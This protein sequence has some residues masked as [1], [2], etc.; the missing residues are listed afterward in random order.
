QR[1]AQELARLETRRTE[2][3][4]EITLLELH[5]A[6]T[7]LAVAASV[8][9]LTDLLD[10]P[11]AFRAP[12]VTPVPSPAPGEPTAAT[13]PGS[14][15]AHAADEPTESDEGHRVDAITSAE[16]SPAEETPAGE[17][18]ADEALAD[19]APADDVPGETLADEMLAGET[20]LF[21]PSW[22][23][24][25]VDIDLGE[26][27][28]ESADL[29]NSIDPEEPVD[30]ADSVDLTESVDGADTE[31]APM[32]DL[33]DADAVTAPAAEMWQPSEPSGPSRPDRS[34]GGAMLAEPS[35]VTDVPSPAPPL[36][37]TAADIETPDSGATAPDPE[38]AAPMQHAQP[39]TEEFLFV[40]EDS[41]AGDDFLDQLRDAVQVDEGDDFGEDAL[42]A[43]FDAGDDKQDKS[44][45][46]RRR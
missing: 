43:F 32:L 21:D 23:T 11:D 12:T 46:N 27:R 8:S 6:E 5:M 37:V 35:E 3:A 40:P 31:P 39:K 41:T 22:S 10:S 28:D 42:A 2:L 19:E 36:L 20:L 13:G 29:A 38:S 26:A 4:D 33:T 16:D 15:P 34:S 14:E 44:W 45:F 17:M 30:H 7:R 9:A 1:G 24:D 18:L 25:D